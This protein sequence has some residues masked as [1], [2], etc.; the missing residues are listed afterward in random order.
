MSPYLRIPTR[1]GQKSRYRR[2]AELPDLAKVQW[3]PQPSSRGLRLRHDVAV[4][5]VVVV[6]KPIGSKRQQEVESAFSVL[7]GALPVLTCQ[8]KTEH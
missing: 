6:R 1:F 4:G 2:P 8:P 3:N 7:S 5:D